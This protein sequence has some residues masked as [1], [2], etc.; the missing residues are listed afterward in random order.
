MQKIAAK[1][2]LGFSTCTN[3][4]ENKGIALDANVH[5]FIVHLFTLSYLSKWSRWSS[6]KNQSSFTKSLRTFLGSLWIDFQKETIIFALPEWD[7]SSSVKPPKWVAWF[8]PGFLGWISWFKLL[9]IKTLESEVH[10]PLSPLNTKH[11][12][13]VGFFILFSLRVTI[14][15]IPRFF[16][17][18][19]VRVFFFFWISTPWTCIHSG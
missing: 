14:I 18:F 9:N 4:K 10:N 7:T 17:L 2:S 11:P 19:V 8:L 12:T 16:R 1:K 3:E 5:L 13:N 6:R 15:T